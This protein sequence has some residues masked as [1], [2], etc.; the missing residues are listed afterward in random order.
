MDGCRIVKFRSEGEDSCGEAVGS[1]QISHYFVDWWVRA[2]V[3]EDV[4]CL[5]GLECGLIAESQPFRGFLEEVH[6]ALF[7]LHYYYS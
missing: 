2:R 6:H 1:R 7:E 4:E 5:Y 3:V